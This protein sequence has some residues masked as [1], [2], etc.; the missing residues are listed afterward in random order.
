MVVDS[1]DDA[2][3]FQKFNNIDE[4]NTRPKLYSSAVVSA[5]LITWFGLPTLIE[6]EQPSSTS[7]EEAADNNDDGGDDEGSDEFAPLRRSPRSQSEHVANKLGSKLH[8]RVTKSFFDHDDDGDAT[9]I[10][11]YTYR[12]RTRPT[13]GSRRQPSDDHRLQLRQ[14]SD[15]TY[16]HVGGSDMDTFMIYNYQKLVRYY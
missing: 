13:V 6:C 3:A 16:S 15:G 14:N 5:P 2:A 8:H 4:N 1:I 10:S 12:V 9:S 7:A 11:A